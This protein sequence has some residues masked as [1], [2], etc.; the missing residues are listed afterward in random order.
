VEPG[1]VVMVP[2]EIFATSAMIAKGHRLRVALGASNLP[3]GMPPLPTL[4]SSFAGVP[5]IYGD[6]NHASKVVLPVVPAAALQG[7]GCV[8]VLRY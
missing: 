4:F 3:H 5:T 6:A 8:R 2:V 1:N 7:G